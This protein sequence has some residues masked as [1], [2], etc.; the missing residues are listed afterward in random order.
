MV[1]ELE[2]YNVIF[3]ISL[4]CLPVILLYKFN[5]SKNILK[6]FIKNEDNDCNCD[7]DNCGNCNCLNC[8][9]DSDSDDVSD[10]VSD[11]SNVTNNTSNLNEKSNIESDSIQA[12]SDDIVMEPVLEET[13][14]ND[15]GSLSCTDPNRGRGPRSE[16]QEQSCV[17][18]IGDEIANQFAEEFL[19]N[20]ELR[21][22]NQSQLNSQFVID[23]KI[24]AILDDF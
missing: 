24:K 15:H 20:L 2:L 13:E 16:L 4:L 21:K 1:N 19:N 11:C 9:Y 6:K 8:N 17:D 18:E 3:N 22:E 5:T 10:D 7:C 12:C 14:V 23:K